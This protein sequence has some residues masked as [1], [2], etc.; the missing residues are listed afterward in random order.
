MNK[1]TLLKTVLLTPLFAISTIV[2]ADNTKVHPVPGKIEAEMFSNYFDTTPKNEGRAFRKDEGVG[3]QKT[4]DVDGNFNVGWTRDGEWLEYEIEVKNSGSYTI[5]LRY[6]AP[7]ANSKIMLAV[8][9]KELNTVELKRT[10]NH[11]KY[12]N[13]TTDLGKLNKGK[14]TLRLNIV[15]GSFNVNWFELNKK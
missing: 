11:H 1:A 4:K 3:I 8:D 12:S 15:V 7:K 5:N 6:A 2:L 13:L 14:H 9:G 10:G